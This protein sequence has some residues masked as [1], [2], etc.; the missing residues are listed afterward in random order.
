[1]TERPVRALLVGFGRVGRALAEILVRRDRY[2]SLAA[3]AELDRLQ[4]VGITTG[5]SGALADL[6]GIDLAS[7]LAVAESSCPSNAR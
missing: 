3:R 2:P 6:A 4:V 7:A 5:S 1:M